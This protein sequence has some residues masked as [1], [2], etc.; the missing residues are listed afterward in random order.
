MYIR[1]PNTQKTRGTKKNIKQPKKKVKERCILDVLIRFG[2]YA[3]YPKPIAPHMSCCASHP[4]PKSKT[5][6][7]K[8]PTNKTK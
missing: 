5:N 1:C 4:K 3:C 2:K 8:K 7:L 6:L